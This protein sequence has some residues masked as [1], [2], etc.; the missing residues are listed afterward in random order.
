MKIL[1][2]HYEE[3]VTET[4]TEIEMVNRYY[5]SS[6]SVYAIEFKFDVYNSKGKEGKDIW[7]EMLFIEVEFENDIINSKKFSFCDKHPLTESKINNGC[8]TK[9]WVKEL[10]HALM[11]EHYFDRRTK[12]QFDTDYNNVITNL[13][14][15]RK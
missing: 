1:H 15:L 5:W 11:N 3:I 13:S 14:K 10:Y 7:N 2:K 4:S 12:E 8:G 6:R 9:T